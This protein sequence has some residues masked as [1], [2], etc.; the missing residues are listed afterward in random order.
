[1]T[2]NGVMAVT[3]RYFTESG[4]LALQK[5]ICGGIYA[6]VYCIFSAC[7]MSSYRKF[8]I[9]SPDEFL[10]KRIMFSM[11]DTT[12]KNQYR[13]Q[14]HLFLAQ[15]IPKMLLRPGFTLDSAGQ[16]TALPKPL[17]NFRTAQPAVGNE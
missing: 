5:T 7:T 15:N 3:V 2:L 10:V 1:M 11:G 14:A 9:S 4:K 16:F 8:A 13:Q 17:L 6:I 12:K